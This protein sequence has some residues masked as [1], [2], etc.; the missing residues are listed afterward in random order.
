M[1]HPKKPFKEVAIPPV[2]DIRY[3][4][5]SSGPP[6]SDPSSDR[7]FHMD[8]SEELPQH[9][10]RILSRA[11][12]SGTQS[13]LAGPTSQPQQPT[14]DL[15]RSILKT[16]D[17][18]EADQLSSLMQGEMAPLKIARNVMITAYV[19]RKLCSDIRTVADLDP[20]VNYTAFTKP[21]LELQDRHRLHELEESAQQILARVQNEP[22]I[23][24]FN[25]NSSER[26]LPTAL[27]IVESEAER[28]LS[29][30]R[31]SFLKETK[32]IKVTVKEH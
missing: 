9:N 8:T 20:Q 17:S 26:S 25:R 2:R 3:L 30:V 19:L 24:A 7:I 21:L 32:K 31:E 27:P 4:G 14:Q 11:G 1:V 5:G 22:V 16:P 23:Q 10:D 13:R 15:P 28:I 12:Q 6:P 29:H 18:P